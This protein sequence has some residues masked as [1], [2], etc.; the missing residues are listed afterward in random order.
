MAAAVGAALTQ[1]ALNALCIFTALGLGQ[2]LPY[3]LLSFAHWMRRVL[4]KPGAWMDTLKQVF[5]FPIYASAAWL[6]WVLSQQTSSV[7]LGAAL[8]GSFLIAFAAWAHQES[9][10]GFNRRRGA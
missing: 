7:G 4:P 8:G 9:K 3:V 1:S 10:I 2:A 6:L 5:A